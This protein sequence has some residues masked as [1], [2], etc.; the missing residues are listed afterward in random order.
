MVYRMRK[1]EIRCT[2]C[3]RFHVD[4]EEWA[5]RPHHTHLC[6]H[7]DQEFEFGSGLVGVYYV[8]VPPYTIR[9]RALA[10]VHRAEDILAL[11]LLS[12]TTKW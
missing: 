5:S 1:A 11:V 8:G 2:F 3:G 7:C 4:Y 9:G 6:E 12:V 10:L